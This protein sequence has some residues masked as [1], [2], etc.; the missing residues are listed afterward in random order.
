[1][2]NY[3]GKIIKNWNKVDHVKLFGGEMG[4]GQD[5]EHQKAVQKALQFF[6]A[7][8]AQHIPEKFADDKKFLDKRE[9]SEKAKMQYFATLND[10]PATAKEVVD[11][12]HELAVYDNGFEQIFN[13]RDFTGRGETAFLSIQ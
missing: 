8:P 7:L 13:I 3:R 10:F 9:S 11:K 1:M 6:F 5:R 12:Y 2:D 4:E